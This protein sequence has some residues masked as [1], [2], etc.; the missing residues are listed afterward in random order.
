MLA[1]VSFVPPHMIAASN[2]A[3]VKMAVNLGI[4]GVAVTITVILK[5]ATTVTLLMEIQMMHVALFVRKV[6]IQVPLKQLVCLV[7]PSVHLV[8][9]PLELAQTVKKE[10]S[11]TDVSS[12]VVIFQTVTNVNLI[13]C[14]Q[15]YSVQSA[16]TGIIC[17]KV[18]VKTVLPH[19]RDVCVTSRLGTVLT[20]LKDI[21]GERTE[22]HIWSHVHLNAVYTVLMV[23]VTRMMAHVFVCQD[24]L[25][26]DAH[27][28]VQLNVPVALG[29]RIGNVLLARLVILVIC[30]INGVLI[31]VK[32]G[33]V[34]VPSVLA[35]LV[36]NKALGIVTLAV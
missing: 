4:M 36:V 12:A 8:T 6:I 19:V 32:G 28:V 11:G 30:V 33:P 5:I 23:V 21:M 2:L 35:Y 7:V 24:G 29:I 22:T 17:H 16:R 25:A 26:V 15:I 1:V 20:V 9:H 18:H 34:Q 10:P 3:I 14:E 13:I 31:H 27:E